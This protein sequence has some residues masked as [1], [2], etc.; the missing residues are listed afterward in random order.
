[1]ASII[2]GYEYDIF[3]SYRQKDN[4][5]DGWVTEFVDHLKR[6]IEATF[7]EDVSV[8]FDENPH[9]GLLEIHNVDKS[10]E[11]KLKSVVF[12][13]VISQTYCDPNSFAWQSE[14]VAFN[15]MAGEDGFGRDITLP[16]GNVCSRIIPVRIHDLDAADTELLENE[17]GCRLRSIDFIFSS[18]GVNRPLKPGD[19]PDKNLNRTYYRDQI[20]K[21]AN[22]VK[23][24]IY[25]MH[26]DEKKRVV[27]TYR[28]R[29]Q[30][31]YTAEQVRPAMEKAVASKPL[32]QKLIVPAAL[33]IIVT[34]AIIFGIPGIFQKGG[35]A[36]SDSLERK[37][38]AV[39]PVDNFTGNPDLDWIAEMIQSDLTGQLQGISN[40]T[41]RP[42]QTTLQF[43][44]SEESVHEI[45]KKLSVNN[46]IES[47]I[48]GTEDQL[49]V[50]IRVVEAF[51]EER[52]LYRST[53]TESFRDLANAY[54]EIINRIL[55]GLEVK[56]TEHEATV[57]SARKVNPEVR[58]ACARGL[59]YMNQLTAEG[60][61]LGMKYYKEAIAIDPADPEPHIGLARGY[62]S[63]GHGAGLAS[64]ELAKAHAIKA[65]ELDPEE[66]HPNLADAH[67]V[68]AETY[69][70]REYD[71]AR[72]E[73]HLKR[74]IAL[75]P[76]SDAAHYTYGWQLALTDQV[77]EAAE[78]M[79]R[80][81]A[82]N[83]LNPICP[84]YLAWLYQWFGRL[85]EAIPFAQDALKI[86][87]KYPMSFYV[88]GM[89]YS[90]M[91]RHDEAIETL[92]QIYTPRSGYASGMGVAY[93]RAG[94]KD[95]ALEI[96]A[97]MEAQ[98]MRWHTWGLADV[99][100][101]LGDNEKAIYWLEEAYKQ[102]HDFIPWIRNNRHYRNLRNDPRFQ[103]IVK[104]LN[105]PEYR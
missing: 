23:E 95:K 73:Y 92:R 9:D 52:Y 13:P 2:P 88:L 102:R 64:L 35:K 34:L 80:A 100:A 77:D 30:E 33:G 69:L 103:D 58:K 97:E 41:V 36:S 31:G 60:M 78:E 79:K 47:S 45:A 1:M 66:L 62:A 20:N 37:A 25:G 99:Y 96:A 10:L 29:T 57:L 5:Y 3:V 65:I 15:R 83:P 101:T 11:N 48:K 90:E 86:N 12:I 14:F 7:K 27:K 26:P 82:I 105:L 8:Y 51:P 19:N 43:R 87:P 104:R 81:M 59:Y 93:A 84:G 49:Q 98:N 94:Q 50:E 16:G 76:N 39:M 28:T 44:N 4:K 6:E 72:S 54:N 71:F 68:L 74:A 40:L 75:N 67:V 24:I 63:G 22:A 18:A 17:L 21:V 70:Y 61:E 89:V 46:L 38:I 32:T 91:G 56:P 85:E 53:F 42:K 55:R